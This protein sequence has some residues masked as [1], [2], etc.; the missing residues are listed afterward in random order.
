MSARILVVDDVPANVKLLE[1]RLSAEYFD[2]LTASN[3]AEALQIC[4]RA[5]CDIILLDVMM[6][7]MDG[8]EVCAAMRRLPR[9]IGAHIPILMVTGLDDVGSIERAY[10]AGATDFTTK[11]INWTILLQ[12]LRYMLR[13]S[14]SFRRLGE[15][16]RRLAQAQKIAAL[17]SWEW[18]TRTGAMMWSSEMF[19]LLGYPPAEE[20]DPP[21]APCLSAILAHIHP[22][23]R[24]RFQT[25]AEQIGAGSRPA[26]STS[27]SSSPGW[28]T[29]SS[30]AAQNGLTAGMSRA[31]TA[32]CE[33]PTLAGEEESIHSC[34][35]E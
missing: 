13:A 31:S 27:A 6:P 23:D 19:S 9:G 16:E 10:T 17:G 1:A 29:R 18:D 33:R 21:V 2:V 28:G 25:A 14:Q 7:D 32:I 12:R 11:P 24:E 30:T 26:G 34:S 20:M 5:E 22:D 8:F 15:S 4:Q 3:G 35:A